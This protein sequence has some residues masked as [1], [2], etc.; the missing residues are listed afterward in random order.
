M[1][2]CARPWG[3]PVS[4]GKLI[5]VFVQLMS[6]EVGTTP[7]CQVQALLHLWTQDSGQAG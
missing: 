7:V 5:Q 6:K 1:P 3:P 4:T 2:E